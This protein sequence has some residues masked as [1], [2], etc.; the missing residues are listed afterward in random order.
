MS[1]KNFELLGPCLGEVVTY[2]IH[3]YLKRFLVA[4]NYSG[5]AQTFWYNA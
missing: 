5:R 1:I 4:I 2:V 3:I